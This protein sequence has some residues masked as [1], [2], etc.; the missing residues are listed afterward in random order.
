MVLF[1]H[2][3]VN[4]LG[5]PRDK[6]I[7]KTGEG[8]KEIFKKYLDCFHSRW[9]GKPS[10]LQKRGPLFHRRYFCSRDRPRSTHPRSGLKW[11]HS[12]LQWQIARAIHIPKA[13]RRAME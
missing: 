1:V 4:S 10:L 5:D 6:Q 2:V 11:C 13:N 8:I 9:R 7:H 3:T 12:K